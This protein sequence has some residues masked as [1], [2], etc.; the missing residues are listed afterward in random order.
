MSTPWSRVALW[1]VLGAVVGTSLDAL[2][3]LT[4]TLVYATTELGLQAWWVP[5]EF[6]LAGVALGEGHHFLARRLGQRLPA[7]STAEVV[8]ACLGLLLTYGASGFLKGV[9][10]VALVLFV[11][12][13]VALLAATPTQARKTLAIHAVGTALSGPLVEATLCA[14]GLFQYREAASP[15]V[16]GVPVWLPRIYLHAALATAALDRMLT[17]ERL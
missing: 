16:L 15:L 3:V 4:G 1:A 17:G 9:P 11:G 13:F 2:H 8:R 7:A 14:L 12:G 6:A 5:P 10:H